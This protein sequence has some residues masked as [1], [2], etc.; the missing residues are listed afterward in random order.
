M[1]IALF[2]ISLGNIRNVKIQGITGK[3]QCIVIK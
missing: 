1:V 3:F 2:F